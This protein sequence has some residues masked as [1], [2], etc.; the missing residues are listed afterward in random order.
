MLFL[1]SKENLNLN[2]INANY[3]VA[4]REVSESLDSHIGEY[5]YLACVSIQDSWTV[6]FL[7]FFYMIT[8]LHAEHSKLAPHLRSQKKRRTPGMTRRRGSAVQPQRGAQWSCSWR[9]SLG[10]GGLLR[11]KNKCKSQKVSQRFFFTVLQDK[12]SALT[13]SHSKVV[14]SIGLTNSVEK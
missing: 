11:T 4:I 12:Q 2:G 7:F 10:H 13:Q 6:F 5:D 3:Y 1:F 8:H 14:E 9:C